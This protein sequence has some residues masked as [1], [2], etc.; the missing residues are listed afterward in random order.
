MRHLK[1]LVYLLSELYIK[2]ARQIFSSLG[3][4]VLTVHIIALQNILSF[5]RSAHIV[6]G[7]NLFHNNS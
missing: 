3:I 2:R 7:Y 1:S 5:F 4:S 6:S